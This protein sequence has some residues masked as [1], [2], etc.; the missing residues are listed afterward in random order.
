MALKED[1]QNLTS[2]TTPLGLYKWKRLPMG[3]AFAPGEFQNLME[4][5]FSGH[6]DEVALL[7]L[8]DIIVFVKT[9]EEPL[10]FF[11]TSAC[12]AREKRY[13]DKRPQMQFLP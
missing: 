12:A 13:Q 7:Y 6:F 2:V 3:L 11:R 5:V 9:F 10:L 4:L 1:C 8:D